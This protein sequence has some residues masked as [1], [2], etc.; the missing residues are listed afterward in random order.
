MRQSLERLLDRLPLATIILDW[1]LRNSY[2][3]RAEEEL[4]VLWNLGPEAARSLKPRLSFALPRQ[5]AEACVSLKNAQR[6]GQPETGM[7]AIADHLAVLHPE[8]QSLRASV[9]LLRM[10]AAPLSFPMFLVRLESRN[11]CLGKNEDDRAERQ[12]ALWANLS[13]SEQRVA[14]FA[15]QGY[16]NREIAV[17]LN[18]STM[19]VKKQLQSI[20]HRLGVAGRNRLIALIHSGVDPEIDKKQER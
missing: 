12:L 6:C 19:T 14:W 18:K 3:N 1:D 17:R 2:Q 11:G 10:N 13:P 4:S 8:I 5:I 7:P 15:G 20:Y 9:S 16:Q